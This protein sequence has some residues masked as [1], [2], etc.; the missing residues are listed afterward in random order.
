MIQNDD[1]RLDCELCVQGE[2]C[3]S[4]SVTLLLVHV[5]IK[6]FVW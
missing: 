3:M 5:Y 2:C 1:C 6:E 4:S